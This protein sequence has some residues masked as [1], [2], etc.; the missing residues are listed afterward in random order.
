MP[1]SWLVFCTYSTVLPN[2][3]SNANIGTSYMHH[4]VLDRA[5]ACINSLLHYLRLFEGPVIRCKAS[6]ESTLTKGNNKVS[7]P[8]EAKEMEHMQTK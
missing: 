1:H 7:Y 5:R 3:L 4:K 2:E 6:S 8:E